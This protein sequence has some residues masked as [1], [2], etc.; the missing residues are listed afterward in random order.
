M[1]VKYCLSRGQIIQIYSDWHELGDVSPYNY[2]IL[3]PKMPF[4]EAELPCI[5]LPKLVHV[6]ES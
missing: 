4:H 2:C 5:K 6:P 1:S 3:V